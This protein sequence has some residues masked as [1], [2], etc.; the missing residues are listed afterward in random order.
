MAKKKRAEER[1]R[2]ELGNRNDLATMTEDLDND[3]TFVTQHV[4]VLQI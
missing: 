2:A 4:G 3:A 1:H